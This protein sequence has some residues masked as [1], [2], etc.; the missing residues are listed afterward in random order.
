MYAWTAPTRGDFV[1][2]PTPELSREEAGAYFKQLRLS[3]KLRLQDVVDGTTVPTVQYLSALEGGR[4]HILN[5]DHFNSLAK[6]FNLPAEEIERIRPG[7]ILEIVAHPDT[8]RSSERVRI[9]VYAL[10]AAGVGTWTDDEVV[11]YI[12]VEPDVAYRRNRTTFQV[13]GDSMEPTLSSGDYIHVDIADQDIRDNK[14]YVIK[15]KGNGIVVKRARV[16]DD[17]TV[18]LL[19]DNPRHPPLRPDD[20]I[21]IGRVFGYNQ[22]FRP[23]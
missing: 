15:V 6:F 22:A 10:A 5:S 13:D 21:V 19:S 7:T 16:Y 17:G 14:I 3:R 2:I 11:D 8:V 1:P 20:A 4:Y 23:L 18:S 12:E 9:P